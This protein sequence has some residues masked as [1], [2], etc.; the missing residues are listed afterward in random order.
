MEKY[1]LGLICKN[2]CVLNAHINYPEMVHEKYLLIPKFL[3][4]IY[5]VIELFKFK[6]KKLNLY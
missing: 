1:N 2:S 6:W 3:F 5:I 4:K